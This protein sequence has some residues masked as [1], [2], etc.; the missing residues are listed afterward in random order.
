LDN[1]TGPA[2]VP[3]TERTL[4]DLVVQQLRKQIILGRLPPGERLTEARLSD[5]LAVSRGTV[6][7]ALRRLEAESLVESISHR[8]SRVAALS[9]DDAVQISEIHS[10]LGSHTVDQ[11]DLPIAKSLCGRLTQ[12]AHEMRGLRVPEDVDRFIELDNQFHRAIVE[13]IGQRRVLQVW[14]G[15]SALHSILV[16]ISLRDTDLSGDEI[17]AR[18]EAIITALCQPDREMASRT[19]VDHYRTNEARLRA[20]IAEHENEKGE[21]TD[22]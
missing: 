14:S 12:I 9:P 2:I 21:A 1:E 8:G 18:H 20:L 16:G 19:V 4:A 6:R 7:E 10:I 17:A 13:A 15:V 5:E 22:D 3:P 11:L